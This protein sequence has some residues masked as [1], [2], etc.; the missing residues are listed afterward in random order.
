MKIN[1][2]QVISLLSTLLKFIGT[3]VVAHGTLG[4]NGAMWE[5]ISGAVLMLAPVILDMF[6]HTDGATIAA[7]AAMPDVEKIVVQP[8]AGDGVGA[9]LADPTQAKVVSR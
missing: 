9:A 5:Q 1:S 3:A 6:R 4:I 8:N 7:V 2:A